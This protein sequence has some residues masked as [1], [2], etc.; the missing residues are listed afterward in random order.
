MF[1]KVLVVKVKGVKVDHLQDVCL[2][3]LPL[4]FAHFLYSWQHF[5]D[6]SCVFHLDVEVALAA[7]FDLHEVDPQ[8]LM[9]DHVRLAAVDHL[10][11]FHD[12]EQAKDHTDRVMTPDLFQHLKIFFLHHEIFVQENQ[13]FAQIVEVVIELYNVLVEAYDHSDIAYAEHDIVSALE[14]VVEVHYVKVYLQ[15]AF[16]PAIDPEIATSVVVVV[17]DITMEHSVKEV[18]ASAAEY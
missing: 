7:C 12:V 2:L 16:E 18:L 17:L 15:V 8:L 13:A 6:P 5:F 9:M 3:N 4:D 11:L 14:L 10:L 1:A